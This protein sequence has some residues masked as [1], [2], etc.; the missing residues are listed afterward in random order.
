MQKGEGIMNPIKVAIC[1][2]NV[3]ERKYFCN[4]CREIKDKQGLQIKVGQYET[5]DSLLFDFEDSKVLNDVDIVLLDIYMPGTSGIDVAEK[6]RKLNFQGFIIFVTRSSEYW[7]NAFDL[8]A[9]NY[10][11]KGDNMKERFF[12]V[13]IGA[14]NEVRKKKSKT[15]FFS[16]INENRQIDID[17]ISYFEVDKHVV[18]VHYEM[19]K[20][21]EFISSL[22]KIEHMLY[23]NSDFVRVHR[24]YL[25]SLSHVASDK[26]KERSLEMLNG[27]IV[28]VSR[29][30][31]VSLREAIANQTISNI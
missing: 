11:V 7:S 19:D 28:P 31:I 1:D 24:S 8:K 13:F 4:L 17:S 27:D 10:I 29:K 9:F 16:S 6:I 20:T 26:I 12:E 23:G 2:D 5:G 22:L 25:V 3:E 15:L 21:F 14:V 18:T 30:H